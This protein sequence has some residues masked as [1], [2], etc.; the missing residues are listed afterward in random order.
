MLH[1]IQK[2]KGENMPELPEVETIVSGLNGKIRG[3]QFKTVEVELERQLSNCT[4]TTFQNFIENEIIDRVERV[5]K[6]LHFIFKSGKS[7]V[8]HLRMTG[9]FIYAPVESS[10]EEKHIRIAFSFVDGSRLLYQ[11]IRTFG[12]FSIYERGQEVLEKGKIGIE[13]LSDRLTAARLKELFKKRKGP[14]KNVLLNQS[15][16]AGIGN[17]YACEILFDINVNPYTPA[18]ELTDEDLENL[19]VSTKKILK[20]AIENN[21][22][23]I[24]DYRTV[25]DKTGSFQNMLKVYQKKDTVCTK[26]GK[27]R[28]VRTT[29]AQRSTFYCPTCQ[30]ERWY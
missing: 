7:F 19:V 1:F 14:I 28:I 8:T 5:G 17:I 2:S 20:L 15:L 25:E 10:E 23:S 29:I 13:P 11:D 27:D 12:T 16:I 6:Y 9:K 18:M 21:G 4:T 26:C 3:R 30:P 24:S 22:T